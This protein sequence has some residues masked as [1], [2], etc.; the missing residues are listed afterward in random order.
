MFMS[1]CTFL[2]V[3][4]SVFLIAFSELIGVYAQLRHDAER[5]AM[6]AALTL[7]KDDQ[8]GRLNKLTLKARELV[9]TSRQSYSQ[10]L[11]PDHTRYKGLAEALL[12]ES[13]Q[14]AW[15]LQEEKQTLVESRLKEIHEAIAQ[16]N[17]EPL[18]GV[19]W[20]HLSPTEVKEV[21]LG[22]ISGTQSGA[23]VSYFEP[24]LVAHDVF[25]KYKSRDSHQYR[26]KIDVK[27]PG[28][29][30]DLPFTL[31]PLPEPVTGNAQPA[32]LHHFTKFEPSALYWDNGEKHEIDLRQPP[33][34]IR[35]L[36]ARH[37]KDTIL[38]LINHD[39]A[40]SSMA[41]TSGI[42]PGPN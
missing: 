9:Y 3:L 28:D 33:S 23:F 31:T 35:V 25:C 21:Y 27:L 13:R 42:A 24:E 38:Q 41:E 2:A 37:V 30:N 19:A 16:C 18:P 40:I 6:T 20:L 12:E 34:S 8:L 14:A 36:M 26:G 22:D 11:K 39:I 17:S 5:L 29:D 7:N 4:G 1:L 10:T 15:R 32:S